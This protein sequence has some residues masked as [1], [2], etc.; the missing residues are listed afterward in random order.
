MRDAIQ[1]VAGQVAFASAPLLE[2]KWDV[3]KR[4]FVADIAHPLFAVFSRLPLFV[5]SLLSK[6]AAVIVAQMKATFASDNDPRERAEE[7]VESITKVG[8]HWLDADKSS[9]GIYARE[10]REPLYLRG[11]LDGDTDPRV[12]RP[13]D[14]AFGESV[15][16]FSE[17]LK[18]VL[19]TLLN[20]FQHL[21]DILD[22]YANMEKVAHRVNEN[23]TRFFEL[24]RLIQLMWSKLDIK[25]I[26][27]GCRA[28]LVFCYD[29]C[30]AVSA[31][32]AYRS[33]PRNWVP[34]L[35]SPLDSC[36][37]HFRIPPNNKYSMQLF[38]FQGLFLMEA[39]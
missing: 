8:E 10:M 36:F 3:I 1:F 37:V 20:G 6:T 16:A 9:C 12:C 5:F 26:W 23:H 11:A 18:R 15:R 21:L 4:A 14:A 19:W 2:E 33:A 30:I 32:D 25:A 38:N 28:T 13:F 27:K 7:R 22:W 34:G 29:F 17:Q 31:P 39:K 24:L 35:L